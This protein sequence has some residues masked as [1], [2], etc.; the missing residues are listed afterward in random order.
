MSLNRQDS[1]R[2]LKHLEHTS[3]TFAPGIALL[4][5]ELR[6]S[7]AIAYL[8]CRIRDSLE[9]ESGLD[10]SRRVELLK[11]AARTQIASD[12]SSM[13]SWAK[14]VALLFADVSG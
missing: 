6:E 8:L 7:V 2:L 5:P 11:E 4:R 12:S 1:E 10:A 14:D 9:D 3:R 13:E